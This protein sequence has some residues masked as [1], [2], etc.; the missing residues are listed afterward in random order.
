[1]R[2]LVYYIIVLCVQ[3]D[4]ELSALL[5]RVALL[6]Q[7]STALHTTAIAAATTAATTTT[8]TT[9]ATNSKNANVRWVTFM[10]DFIRKTIVMCVFLL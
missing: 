5:Q 4:T 9:A 7:S 3:R 1:M 2:Y 6:Q 10:R 8:T